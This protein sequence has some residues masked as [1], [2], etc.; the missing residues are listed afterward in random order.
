MPARFRGSSDRVDG[1]FLLVLWENMADPIVT[2]REELGFAKV[3]GELPPLVLRGDRAAAR[4]HWDG[5]LFAELEIEGLGAPA[6]TWPEP[7][8]SQGLLHY[9]YV[10]RTGA[11]GK[12]DSEYPVL[13]PA[14][15]GHFAAWE[16]PELFARELR[17]AF[18]SFR[19]PSSPALAAACDAA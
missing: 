3:Y 9:K 17:T 12:S 5:H 7:P 16:Q 13:T 8:L 15:G 11:P 19:Q 2:G 6:G 1:D 4:A 14:S 18:Q 10:P